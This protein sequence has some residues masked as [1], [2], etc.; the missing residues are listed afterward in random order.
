MGIEDNLVFLRSELEAAKLLRGACSTRIAQQ[1]GA[2]AAQQQAVS[3]LQ[4]TI[5]DLRRDVAC[6]TEVSV[7]KVRER[8]Q[9]EETIQR[10]EATRDEF[11]AEVRKFHDM[12]RRYTENRKRHAELPKE[13]FS[14]EDEDKLRTLSARFAENMHSFG[15]RSA[16]ISELEISKDCYRPVRSGFEIAFGSSA[17]DN[18]RI[19]WAYT[20]ALL[21]TGCTHETNHWG[22]CVFDEPEQ[23]NMKDASCDAFYRGIGKL[24]P[25]KCQVIVTTSAK[26]EDIGDWLAGFGH[27]LLECEDQVIGFA[28]G[29]L[30]DIPNRESNPV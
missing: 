8:V 25:E 1:E 6:T 2:Y 11:D 30:E 13:Y 3:N 16:P 10:I 5:R 12:S 19:I 22:V 17:S 28:D 21:Q 15:F 20:L 18:V 26:K 29:G 14:Q 27:K 24:P 23:Q 7:A 9:Q 4:A